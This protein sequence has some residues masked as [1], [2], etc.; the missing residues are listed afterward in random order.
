MP[1]TTIL[2]SAA[3]TLYTATILAYSIAILFFAADFALALRGASAL[4]GPDGSRL[5]GDD[6]PAEAAVGA[7]SSVR[8]ARAG[9]IAMRLTMFAVSL[10]GAAILTR[11]F[12]AN[13]IPLGNMFEIATVVI[14]V[15]VASFLVICIR[16]PRISGVGVFVMLPI[17][18]GLALNGLFLYAQ[19]GPL[20]AALRS[21]WLVVHVTAVSVGFGAF[22]T[23][24]IV[25][26]LYLVRARH[27]AS[28]SSAV[29]R[30]AGIA[31]RLPR[32][33]T[34]DLA[35]YR[36]VVF[37]FPIFTFA[38][39][40]GAIWAENAWGRFWGWDPKEIWAFIAFI[41]YA[42]YLHARATAGWR[43]RAA[44]RV[45]L[46]GLFVMLFNLLFINIVVAGLHSY[47]GIK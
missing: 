39:I 41:V 9:R 34:L 21:G 10:H 13:R 17:T 26:A 12:A 28:E 42:A 27:E 4:V 37:G 6:E 32:A 25:S 8:G 1:G 33:E 22:L 5:P 38:V 40:A 19:A 14:F 16:E 35:A 23:S 18:L 11:G 3:D 2:A 15:G 43:G 45:N 46:A 36:L 44:A 20:V 31:Q 24:G 29:G 30:L 47:A 7:A